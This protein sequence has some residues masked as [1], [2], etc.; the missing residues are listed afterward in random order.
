MKPVA[1]GVA[2]LWFSLLGCDFAV[3]ARDGAAWHLS[4]T[5]ADGAQAVSRA[6]RIVVSLDREVVPQSVGHGS[7]ALRS[8]AV[9]AA[10]TLR[11]QP[12][13]RELWLDIDPHEPL[14]P[15]VSYR[16]EIDGLVDLDG[17]P[18]PEPYRATFRTG[19]G[20]GAHA[21]DGPFDPAEIRALFTQRC[22]QASCHGGSNPA[23]G[24]DLSSAA[25]IRA[26]A[27]GVRSQGPAGTT[28]EEGVRGALW[29]TG[30]RIVDIVAG[31]GQPATSQLVYKLLGD[32][33]VVGERM[34]PTGAP[35]SLAQLRE[36]SAWIEA[37]APLP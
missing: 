27:I 7:V 32:S 18:Q 8:G 12:V 4:S 3:P 37:G 19:T 20:L 5:P 24:L 21:A 25:G 36:I 28:S 11:L 13:D 33:H 34:P 15:E 35:L 23:S 31:R 2:L 6:S 29:L 1:V 9:A 30:L 17:Q 16:L 14:D 22:A 26:T 10:V